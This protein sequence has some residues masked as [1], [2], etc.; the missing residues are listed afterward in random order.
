MR[1]RRL[2]AEDEPAVVELLQSIGIKD[3]SAGAVRPETLIRDLDRMPGQDGAVQRPDEAEAFQA[4]V[5]VEEDDRPGLLPGHVQAV[6]Q[7]SQNV[8]HAREFV[9]AGEL[10]QHLDG[11]AHLR[12]VLRRKGRLGDGVVGVFVNVIFVVDHLY[13][14]VV[15]ELLAPHHLDVELNGPARHAFAPP[16]VLVEGVGAGRHQVVERPAAVTVAQAAVDGL[17][18]DQG[19]FRDWHEAVFLAKK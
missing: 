12:H 8:L 6:F 11:F 2:V 9:K 10:A 15:A 16:L 3:E 5:L 19:V 1:C 18:S 4:V 17:V 7:P 14:R 13:R